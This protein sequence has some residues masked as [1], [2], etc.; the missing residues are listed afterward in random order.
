LKTKSEYEIEAFKQSFQD[1]ANM[2][3]V[4]YGVG[5]KTATLLN[6]SLGLNI[7]GLL[8]KDI[9][10]VGTKMYGYPVVDRE[11]AEANA[12]ILI[13]NTAESFW[14]TIYQRI[15]DWNIPIYYRNGQKA[16]EYKV[17]EK[18]ECDYWNKSYDDLVDLVNKYDVISFDIF[19]TLVMRKIYLPMDVFSLV[20]KKVQALYGSEFKFAEYRR[21]AEINLENPTIN[22]IYTE[23]QKITGWNNALAE[24]IK[25]CEID[26]D[27]QLIVPREKMVEFCNTLITQKK[28]VCFVS[29]MYYSGKQLQKILFKCG[30][31]ADIDQIIVS[32]ECKKSKKDSTLWEQYKEQY[33]QS[34][35]AL[36]I[37]DNEEAD[38]KNPIKYGIDT[39]HIWNPI[40]M[41]QHSSIKDIDS[42]VNS[43]YASIV[44]G[45][46]NAKIFNDPFVLNA[47]KGMVKFSDLEDIG[48]CVWGSVVY[49][50]LLWI[51]KQ[52]KED[53]LDTIAFMARDG[54]LL[55]KAYE[56]IREKIKCDMP[57]SVYLEISR[58]CI[59]NAAAETWEDVLE[60]ACEAYDGDFKTFL[61]DRFAVEVDL[62]EAQNFNMADIQKDITKLDEHLQKYKT[63]ILK[64][65]NEEKKGYQKYLKSL[66]LGENYG[67]VDLFLYGS[68]QY[69]LGK[70]EKKR[71]QGYYFCINK[72][73]DSKYYKSQGMS[74]CFQKENDLTGKK[75]NLHNYNVFT[76]AFFTSP[77]GMLL[78]IKKD[79]TK[80]YAKKMSNQKNFSIRETMLDGILD[81]I[82][83]TIEILDTEHSIFQNDASF[84]DYLFGCFMYRGF[85]VPK[86]MKESFFWDNGLLNNKES[87]IWE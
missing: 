41:L 44:M 77:Q 9:S 66:N 65:I 26:T 16:S 74:A 33:I 78:Y 6:T 24:E 49:T 56:F 2:K 36:H 45:M 81:F 73:P 76:E 67:V 10:L 48:Y 79:G 82:K 18:I 85:E 46:I 37:G 80:E 20:E 69:Y 34:K 22:E 52:G 11:F 38:V 62:N 32:C 84:S 47:T 13:I 57:K 51:I 14:Q 5:Q 50:F 86:C 64:Q 30:I 17:K 40:K 23:I 35:R 83:V 68:V 71:L 29:D 1:K 21:K 43:I 28:E 63:Q 53:G 27:I 31:D 25:Q 70:F 87:A 58:R 4:L 12:D 75:T 3:I 19:D 8:D 15:K 7:I 55:Q 60:L 59:R 42:K 54:Y 61:Q 72:E 39:Y